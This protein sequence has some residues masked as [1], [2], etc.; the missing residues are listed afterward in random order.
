MNKGDKTN[1]K[2]SFHIPAKVADMQFAKMLVVWNCVFVERLPEEI[3]GQNVKF[4]L[5]KEL[6]AK[7][8]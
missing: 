2:T 8:N 4:E 6:T 1:I 5:D 3:G 7:Q